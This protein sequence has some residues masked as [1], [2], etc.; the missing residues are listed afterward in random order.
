MSVFIN[1]RGLITM[2]GLAQTPSGGSNKEFSARDESLTEQ[3]RIEVEGYG[4]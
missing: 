4:S 3:C 2:R 1:T